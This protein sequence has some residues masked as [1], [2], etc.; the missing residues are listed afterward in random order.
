[1]VAIQDY[2]EGYTSRSQDEKQSECFDVAKVSLHVTNLYC[3][4]IEKNDG[5]ESTEKNLEAVKEHVFLTS[6]DVIQDN[7]SVHSV[8][9]HQTGP[10]PHRDIAHTTPGKYCTLWKKTSTLMFKV[11]T[12]SLE[13]CIS[14]LVIAYLG[15]FYSSQMIR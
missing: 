13:L 15:R 5:I 7:N 6:D 12:Q 1:M 3:H 9:F 14:T 2:S 8:L 11:T 4:S 10:V